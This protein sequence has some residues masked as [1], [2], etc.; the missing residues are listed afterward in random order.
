ME[1]PAGCQLVTALVFCFD[2][3]PFSSTTYF[4]SFLDKVDHQV[5]VFAGFVE[6]QMSP[7]RPMSI[8]VDMDNV[9]VSVISF[10]S[11]PPG[12]QPN[13]EIPGRSVDVPGLRA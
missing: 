6:G 7:Q 13:P 1:N 5:P 3:N 9:Q 11:I 2:K 4:T 8:A 10:T 12:T